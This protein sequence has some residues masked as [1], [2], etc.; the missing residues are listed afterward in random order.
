MRKS[1][2]PEAARAP[3]DDVGREGTHAFK[4]LSESLTLTRGTLAVLLAVIGADELLGR[5][6]AVIGTTDAT[7]HAEAVEPPMVNGLPK[8]SD[9]SLRLLLALPIVI[10]CSIRTTFGSQHPLRRNKMRDAHYLFLSGWSTS[11]YTRC[12]PDVYVVEQRPP[13][14]PSKLFRGGAKYVSV[15]V[16]VLYVTVLGWAVERASSAP[17]MADAA[18]DIATGIGLEVITL[19][20]NDQVSMTSTATNAGPS[21]LPDRETGPDNWEPE[22][23]RLDVRDRAVHST[24]PLGASPA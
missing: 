20:R 10:G 2:L 15:R 18:T 5:S 17:A 12:N 23:R 3:F 14:T 1:E 19:L 6:T 9:A 4:R 16:L 22:D 8:F 7:L 24:V 11:T 21:P 13:R